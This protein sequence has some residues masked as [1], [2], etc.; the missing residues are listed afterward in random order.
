[1]EIP[2]VNGIIDS[3]VVGYWPLDGDVDEELSEHDVEASLSGDSDEEPVATWGVFGD[4]NGALE[5]DGNDYVVIDDL[6]FENEGTVCVWMRMSSSDHLVRFGKAGVAFMN[7]VW[8]PSGAGSFGL[9]AYETGEFNADVVFSEMDDLAWH[10]YC[11]AWNTFFGETRPPEVAIFIDGRFR[12][13]DNAPT[14]NRDLSVSY[15]N[16]NVGAYKEATTVDGLHGVLDELIFFNRML[17]PTEV[18]AY[19]HSGEPFGTSIVPGAQ[20]DFDDIRVTEEEAG[21]SPERITHQI[22][23]PHPHSNTDPE[24]IIAYWRL[25]GDGSSLPDE[26]GDHDATPSS[27]AATTGRFGDANGAIRFVGTAHINTNY[28]PVFGSTAHFT[29]ELWARATGTGEMALF[30]VEVSG[31]DALS[32][33][34]NDAGLVQAFIGP[35]SG[36]ET[37]SGPD[38]HDPKDGRWHHYAV[39]AHP[40]FGDGDRCLTVYVDGNPGVEGEANMPVTVG[41]SLFLGA[42]NNDLVADRHLE[43]GAIDDVLIHNVARS[44][45][46]LYN[47]ANPGLPTVRF[48]A[49]TEANIIS[50]TVPQYAYRAYRLHWGNADAAL[51]PPRVPEP[52]GGEPCEGIYSTCNGYMGWW[53]FNEGYGVDAMDSSGNRNHG[54]LLPESGGPIWVTGFEG[55]ALEFDPIDSEGVWI[56]HDD[57]IANAGNVQMTIEAA[58]SVGTLAPDPARFILSKLS[59][60]GSTHEYSLAFPTDMS[61]QCIAL[62]PDGEQAIATLSSVVLDDFTGSVQCTNNGEISGATVYLDRSGV[63]L[64]NT[65]SPGSGDLGQPLWIGRSFDIAPLGFDGIID[66]VRL[67]NRVLD[68]HEFLHYPL[69]NWSLGTINDHPMCVP[70]AAGDTCEED[71]DCTSLVCTASECVGDGE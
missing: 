22:V 62:I 49:S 68:E 16:W 28:V 55:T 58:V 14:M 30:G 52:A 53:R 25:D 69:S 20:E 38:G 67:M 39:V 10:H 1:M 35:V 54:R 34:I 2:L 18:A 12:P 6:Q 47:R 8:D 71:R 29:I 23:G 56:S 43:G 33:T 66:S 9:E 37:V 17:T 61:V 59:T 3:S 40:C 44:A 50:D 64:A 7:L 41:T 19:V 57:S 26:V 27:T 65:L 51:I 11:V 46:Y 15:E 31:G 24:N 5:F 48:L 60:I 13:L 36:G 70:G 4:A 21:A 32:L 63:S 45:D 42:V